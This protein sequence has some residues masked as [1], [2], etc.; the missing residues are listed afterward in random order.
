VKNSEIMN[1]TTRI[2]VFIS[3][4]LLASGCNEI[5]EYSP[6]DTNFISS[7]INIK[8]AES[9]K[10]NSGDNS[11]Q[12]DTL[13]FAT[14][15]DSHDYYDD[16][17]A[18]MES[19]NKTEGLQFVISCGDVTSRGISQEY[20]WYRE[21]IDRSIC[22]VFTVIGNHDH[23]SNGKV[24]FKRLFGPLNMSFIYMGYKFILFDDVVWENGNKSPDF[25]WLEDEL[26]K[27]ELPSILV[28]HIPPWGEQTAG[29]YEKIFNRII[30]E[31]NI[32]LCL[33]GHHHYPY[34]QIF[35]GVPAI[36]TG[37][38]EK[39][40]YRIIKIFEKKHEIENIKF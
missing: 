39:K 18:A 13:I 35:A 12:N 9:L 14:I 10:N 31:S 38:V 8:N 11:I 22:P 27:D 34:E 7:E 3:V 33:H 6:F 37:S 4:I 28:T 29:D 36:I 19:I 24:I 16:L 23:R 32:I 30:S 17:A 20:M 21:I 15:A 25:D 2:F 26:S 40:G 1:I 5:I